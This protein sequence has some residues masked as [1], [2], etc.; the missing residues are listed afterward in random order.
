MSAPRVSDWAKIRK[1]GRYLRK[2][3]RQVL[4]FEWQRAQA[5]I[6]V[7]VDT[8][9]AGCPRTRRSTNGG[10]ILHGSHLLKTW[11]TTQTMVALSSGEAELHASVCGL[12]RALELR[13]LLEDLTGEAKQ[14]RHFVDSSACKAILMRRGAGAVK[15]L[16]TKQLW[17]Q[18][19]SKNYCIET[20]KIERERNVADMLAS[21]CNSK[22]MDKFKEM[23]GVEVHYLWSAGRAS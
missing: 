3:P 2:H 13:H 19:V 21:W 1:L 15:H 16:S 20:V 18:E 11:A 17:G 10:L 5:S 14:M 23:I 22:Q 8:D 7:Y 12:V 6:K 4:W 9:Y